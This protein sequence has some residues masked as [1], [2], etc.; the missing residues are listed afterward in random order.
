METPDTEKDRPS[1]PESEGIILHVI[2]EMPQRVIFAIAFVAFFFV[3][4]AVNNVIKLFLSDTASLNQNYGLVAGSVAAIVTPVI[5]WCVK[6][7]AK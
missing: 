4:G 7:R 5:L 2:D 3:W 1:I 6:A